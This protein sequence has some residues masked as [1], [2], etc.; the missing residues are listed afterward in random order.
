MKVDNENTVEMTENTS[1]IIIGKIKRLTIFLAL[2][3]LLRLTT[4]VKLAFMDWISAL[5]DRI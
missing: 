2:K 5:F 4:S 3:L 1:L